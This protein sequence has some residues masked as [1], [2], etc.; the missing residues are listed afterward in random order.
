MKKRGIQKSVKQ[1]IA[2]NRQRFANAQLIEDRERAA[3]RQL[4]KSPTPIETPGT[5][6]KYIQN[7][8]GQNVLNTHKTPVFE[9]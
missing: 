9:I 5:V 8:Y 6:P 4:L 7:R 2:A 1:R 3:I